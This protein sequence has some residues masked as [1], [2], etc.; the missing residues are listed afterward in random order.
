M[1]G[2]PSC[3]IPG[4]FWVLKMSFI[5]ALKLCYNFREFAMKRRERRTIAMT[6]SQRKLRENRNLGL[7]ESSDMK[8]ANVGLSGISGFLRSLLRYIR[9]W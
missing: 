7:S 9:M 3:T 5:V 6:G 4:S 1:K 8:G 2:T